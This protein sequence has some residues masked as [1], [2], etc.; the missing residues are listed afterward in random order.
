MRLL[1]AYLTAAASAEA[2]DLHFEP[3]R[4]GLR[5]RMRID[6]HLRDLEPPPAALVPSLL[7]RIRLLSRVDLAERRVPQDGRFSF[8][9][10]R[11]R[12][13]VRAAFLPVARGEKIALRLLPHGN[14]A[15]TLEELGMEPAQRAS[16]DRAL[17]RSNG[18]V[19]VAG[20][21]GSGKSTTLYAALSH[22]RRPSR[23]IVSV[24][25]PVEL[26]V[27][28]VSQVPVD[29]DVGRTFAVAL[30]ALLRQDP[31]VL[32]IGE[33]RDA[34]SARIAC[35][36]ALTGHL[37]LSSVHAS[38]AREAL[39]RM[40]EMG[41]PDYLVRATISLVIAQRLVRRLCSH[42]HSTA[43][44]PSAHGRLFALAG[45]RAPAAVAAPVG[46]DRCDGVGFRGRL[47]LFEVAAC[48][49]LAPEPFAAGSLGACGLSHVLAGET[50]LGETLAHCPQPGEEKGPSCA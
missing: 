3:D 27:E 49:E 19:I 26:D 7:A 44:V 10:G 9:S 43:A 5:V 40:P 50:S 8:E 35:R 42:C 47:A 20:P 38:H 11:R 16:L 28:G 24:E 25:D 48:A 22:L 36:A 6:G 31:D 15:R 46:C 4:E 37:V 13:D 18:L 41:V 29:E 14:A 17:S 12:V 30:R 45:L 1:D 21:T 34:D 33:I 23:S 2:S 32:M 39:L